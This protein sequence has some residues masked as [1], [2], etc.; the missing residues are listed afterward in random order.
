MEDLKGR[1]AIITGATRGIGKALAV[2]LAQ[3]GVSIAVVGKTVEP[4]PKLPG[5]I[6][7][8]VAAVEAA[9]GKAIGLRCDVR[10]SAELEAVVK[11][12]K[13]HFGQVDILINNAGAMWID[14]VTA[15]PEKRFDLVMDINFRAPFLL[16]HL[17]IPHMLEH[18]WGH[19]VNMSP[20]FQPDFI[21]QAGGK[22]A[23][24]ASKLN[25][26]LLSHALGQELN[27]SGVACNSLWP[28]T[29]IDSLA[30]RGLGL[31][32]HAEWRTPEIVVDSTLIILQQDPHTFT[33]QAL[34]DEDLLSQFAGITEYSRYR[35]VPDHEPGPMS[36]K[37][38]GEIAVAGKRLLAM[39]GARTP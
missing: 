27:G 13:D 35:A 23:Y 19:I 17:C 16:S 4:H 1:V 5:T 12:T 25:M 20:P 24:M 11:A 37:R 36:W 21:D 32:Q 15:T 9:G 30:T 10:H 38:L 28:R 3:E 26:T 34:V 14:N 39:L 2:R 6:A 7:E 8:T 31:S 33:G 18:K 22:V 29:L